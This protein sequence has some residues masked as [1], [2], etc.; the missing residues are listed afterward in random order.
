MV[1][2][3]NDIDFYAYIKQDFTTS[4]G[5]SYYTGS[6]LPLDVKFKILEYDETKAGSKKE[7]N[8]TNGIVPGAVFPI[9]SFFDDKTPSDII[10]PKSISLNLVRF[11]AGE[12]I[13]YS[14]SG[15]KGS[16]QYLISGEEIDSI[17][18]FSIVP[19]RLVK[20]EAEFWKNALLIGSSVIN[21]TLIIGFDIKEI[22]D[23][24]RYILV[25]ERENVQSCLFNDTIALC[26]DDDIKLIAISFAFSNLAN[27]TFIPDFS[28]NT[29]QFQG[30]EKKA[31]SSENVETSKD[32]RYTRNAFWVNPL[33]MLLLCAIV[34]ILIHRHKKKKID[35]EKNLEKETREKYVNVIKNIPENY[36]EKWNE[37]SIEKRAEIL[38]SSTNKVFNQID[39]YMKFWGEVDYEK[40]A[41]KDGCKDDLALVIAAFFSGNKGMT[42]IDERNEKNNKNKGNFKIVNPT[43][44]NETGL[45]SK[46]IVELKNLLE[47]KSSE[48]L[49]KLNKNNEPISKISELEKSVSIIKAQVSNNNKIDQI[50]QNLLKLEETVDTIK[51][52]VSNTNEKKKLEELSNKLTEK[53]TI[54]TKLSEN[55]KTAN[56][57]IIEREKTIQILNDSIKSLE[58]QLVIPDSVEVKGLGNFIVFA[59][60]LLNT[61]SKAENNS[62]H[63][64]M[65]IS[66][67]VVKE[68]AGYFITTELASRPTKEIERWISILATLKTKSVIT[69]PDLVKEIKIVDEKERVTYIYKR[70]TESVVVPLVSCALVLLEQFRMGKEWGFVGAVS[71]V[72]ASS[73]K[74]IIVLCKN[75]DIDV[76]YCKLYEELSIYDNVEI[77]VTV[78][79]PVCDWIDTNR[80]GIVLYVKKYS[81]S[82]KL[83]N[84]IEKTSCVVAI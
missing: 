5:K 36:L 14:V 42:K 11:K 54:E 69:D 56:A 35:V 50:H 72:Y 46:E 19:K 78:P 64:W 75:A 47:S 61:I 82:S 73:I 63:D 18:C 1:Y 44:T 65:A 58:K 7:Q 3:Q 84:H 27:M 67:S 52:L 60:H 40:D 6:L 43:S 83:L 33:G 31:T 51:S 2:S 55:L 80:K 15:V 79:A 62:V 57:T 76:N 81:V 39:D 16:V 53:A 66:D 9:S 77:E 20:N 26:K 41:N 32:N 68:R 25:Y 10:N 34:A 45:S 23:S 17:Q 74:E 49:A 71:E 59:Q 28:I 24:A 48:I 12:D 21:D 22:Y 30:C 4:T 38:R 8:I 13:R 70:F 37:V 29:N